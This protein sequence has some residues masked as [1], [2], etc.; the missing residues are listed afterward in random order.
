MCVLNKPY[1]AAIL[2]VFFFALLILFTG[3]EEGDSSHA[4]SSSNIG[5]KAFSED[6]QLKVEISHETCFVGN[7][8]SIAVICRDSGGALLKDIDVIFSSDNGG[9]FSYSILKTDDY[10]AAG[11]NFVP[12]KD[13]TTQISVNAHGISKQIAIQVF[14]SPDKIHFCMITVSSDVVETGKN[15]TVTVYV[16]DSTNAG[17]K[18]AEVTISTQ[19]GSLNENSGKTD[20]NGYFTTMYKAP[21]EVGVDTL[22]AMALGEKDI[23]TIS[24]Q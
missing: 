18:D 20:D 13:G 7:T 6:Q 19:F 10:G 5:L 22:T 12:T 15:L 9:S 1:K 14:P 4:F 21:D 16:C 11:T 23:K 2:L 8:V 3:C 24:V 17:V